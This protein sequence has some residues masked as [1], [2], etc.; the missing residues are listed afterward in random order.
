MR[1]FLSSFRVGHCPKELVNML[2]DGRRTALVLNADDYKT[3]A[4]RS[5]SAEREIQELLSIGLDPYEL[6]LRDY[7]GESRRLRGELSDCDA[8]YVRGGNV[9]VLRRALAH[10][11]MDAVLL[12]LLADDSV[13][14]GG[15][16]AGSAVLGPTLRGVR[17]H[18]DVPEYVP[19]GYPDER[20]IWEGVG[21]IPFAIAPHYRSGHEESEEIERTVEYYIEN[22]I[23]FIALRDGQVL[24]VDGATTRVLG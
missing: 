10:S 24:V 4:D 19:D 7:F 3:P 14:Y 6:D 11:G 21:V 23:P 22:H 12:D 18:V 13:A 15:Y 1:L 20:T 9:F 2:P 5:E 16:S 8:V 17:G